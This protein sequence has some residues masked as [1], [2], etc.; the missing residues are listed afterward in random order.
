MSPCTTQPLFTWTEGTEG[1]G[2]GEQS[3]RLHANYWGRVKTITSSCVH[4]T[5]TF[6][7]SLCSA[8]SESVS[9]CMAS[10]PS[11]LRRR[12]QAVMCNNTD[13]SKGKEQP[14]ISL[15]CGEDDRISRFISTRR[16][17][18]KRRCQTC[19]RI[20]DM[21]GFLRF[22]R[23]GAAHVNFNTVLF[24]FFVSPVSGKR[25]AHTRVRE[26]LTSGKINFKSKL[27]TRPNAN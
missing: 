21:D 14:D 26:V 8:T 7:P 22:S 11:S 9:C 2:G 10:S 16:S 1:K 4:F 6:P 17:A 24:F 5:F 19:D 3:L 20:S 15:R 18:L 23:H 12:K 13:D 27:F 25:A